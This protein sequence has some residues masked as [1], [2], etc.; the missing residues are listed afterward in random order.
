MYY[1][2]GDKTGR[3]LSRVLR[4]HTSNKNIMGIKQ[5]NGTLNVATE[6]IANLYNLPPQHRQ[7]EM[8]EDRTQIIQ[9]YLDKSGL[10]TSSDLDA[11]LLEQG[12][13][14]S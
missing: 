4:V 12:Y 2:S 6:A 9:D 13:A 8:I 5:P 14:I 7:K 11:N 10:P 1:E 3:L